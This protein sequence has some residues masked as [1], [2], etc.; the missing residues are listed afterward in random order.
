[1]RRVAVLDQVVDV[2]IDDDDDTATTSAVA[3]I[4]TAIG[5]VLFAKETTGTGAAVTGTRDDADAID[6]HRWII[7]D[8]AK[9][10]TGEEAGALSRDRFENVN[11]AVDAVELDHAIR[12]SEEGVIAADADVGSGTKTSPAL[13]NND[14]AGD[15][16]FTA[17]FFHAETFAYAVASVAYTC[18]TFFMR[19]SGVLF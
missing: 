12:Q 2:G 3:A 7:A 10:A 13:A 6:K 4:G 19:H 18:L 8:G 15:D 9:S 16:L 17:E 11:A 14:V 1:M 5:H